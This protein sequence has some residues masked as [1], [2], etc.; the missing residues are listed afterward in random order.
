MLSRR[1]L[2]GK[3]ATSAAGAAVAVTA[4]SSATNATLKPSKA[5]APEGS[6]H[7][8]DRRSAAPKAAEAVESTTKVD[9]QAPLELLHP[10][11]IGAD[12]GHGWHVADLT[13]IADG[14]CVL[15][16]AN[17]R[18]RMHRVHLCANHGRP[19]GLVYTKRFDLVVMNGGQGD[20]PTEEGLAQAVAEVAHVLAANESRNPNL[21]AE[22]KSHE[23][24]VRLFSSSE[25]RKLL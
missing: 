2:V 3:L 23:E 17:Q 19:Q 15:S 4:L 8:D 20:M 1:E 22:L 21:V 25:D 16:L 5:G 14:S 24:R 12:V 10:L 9:A 11:K 13:A 18:G 7:D 6:R